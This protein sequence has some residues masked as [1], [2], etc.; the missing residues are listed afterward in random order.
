H[1]ADK[2]GIIAEIKRKSPSKGVLN[3]FI[4]IE[5]LSIGYMQAGANA[6]SVLTDAEFFGGSNED[7]I[8]AR[9]F[10]YCPIL[11]KDF[12]VD[13]YQIIESRSIGADAVLLIAGV[14][15]EGEIKQFAAFSASLG[16]EVLL[17]IHALEELPADLEN[18]SVVGVNNRNLQDFTT[19]VN[20]S[21]EIAAGL[22]NK[23]TKISES[24][25]S[26]AATILELKKAGFQ[27]FLIGE[28]FMR[29]SRPE[30]ACAEFIRKIKEFET[31]DEHR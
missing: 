3:E 25:I 31:A 19:D 28:A 30:A 22:P 2:V 17:E 5:K 29:N 23:I 21:F 8:T 12:I 18:I 13:E 4:S 16:L 11:R 1:R 9:K 20:C 10:N 15:N 7:L 27:G 6:L 26:D 14:L 24:G